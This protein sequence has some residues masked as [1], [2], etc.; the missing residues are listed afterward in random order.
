MRYEMKIG[1]IKEQWWVEKR[2]VDEGERDLGDVSQMRLKPDPVD[3]YEFHYET[4][5]SRFELWALLPPRE[6]STLTPDLQASGQ[7]SFQSWS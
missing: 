6:M 7:K 2:E 3:L 4:L 1:C 5:T